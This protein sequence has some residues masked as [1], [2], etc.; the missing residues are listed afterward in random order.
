[1]A[2]RGAG[3]QADSAPPPAAWAT[4]DGKRCRCRLVMPIGNKKFG[5]P[6]K[7]RWYFCSQCIG[8]FLIFYRNLEYGL[9]KI[10]LNI[11]IFRQNI[12]RFG[13]WFP[14]LQF[15]WY[16]FGF[17]YH[18]PK[19]GISSVGSDPVATTQTADAN[20]P[21]TKHAWLG[22]CGRRTAAAGAEQDGERTEVMLGSVTAESRRG[23]CP[24][25]DCRLVRVQS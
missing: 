2:R 10:W 22:S 4:A 18:F 3:K 20:T 23:D 7:Y 14:W 17:G 25:G 24:S 1:M 5:I 13:I 6:R 8:I 16:R 19:S 15:H 11:G 9:L 12:N 21:H